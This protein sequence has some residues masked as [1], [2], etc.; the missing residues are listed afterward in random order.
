MSEWPDHNPIT[1]KGYTVCKSCDTILC[2]GN[3]GWKCNDNKPRGAKKY[4]D[5]FS[6]SNPM[7]NKPREYWINNR[8]HHAHAKEVDPRDLEAHVI[9]KFAAD[10]LAEGLIGAMKLLIQCGYD[11]S[12]YGKLIKQYRGE[13]DAP[14]K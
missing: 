14:N 7:S 1:Y 11:V 4:I 2:P 13:I 5:S 6:R 3:A 12:E 9:E 8:D 10:K